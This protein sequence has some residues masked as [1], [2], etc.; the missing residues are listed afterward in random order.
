MSHPI[1]YYKFEVKPYNY[2]GVHGGLGKTLHLQVNVNG[3]E[4][5]IEKV[6]APVIPGWQ[7]ELAFYAHIATLALEEKLKQLEEA[8]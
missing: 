8:S 2:T 4:H 1:E 6:M 5:R 3:E 7:T